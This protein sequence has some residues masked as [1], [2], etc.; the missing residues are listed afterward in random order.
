MDMATLCAAM[1]VAAW[2]LDRWIDR[3]LRIKLALMLKARR[4]TPARA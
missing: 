1:V 4:L 3:P 2:A